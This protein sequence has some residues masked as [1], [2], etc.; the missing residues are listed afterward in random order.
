MSGN[1]TDNDE[2]PRLDAST[3][4]DELQRLWDTMLRLDPDWD[5]NGWLIE[6]ANE[7]MKIIEANL[8]RE[9]MRLEQRI[10]RLEALANRIGRDI[11]LDA[12]GTRQCNLFDVFGPNH[13]VEES[14]DIDD[15]AWEIHPAAVHLNYLPADIGD[16]PLLAVCAQAILLHIELKAADGQL[17][18]TLESLGVALIPRG[19]NSDELVEALEWLLEQGSVVETGENEFVLG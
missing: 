6:R 12:E 15:D 4:P 16:D 13:S 7:E 1:P 3:L 19:I 14:Q 9:K 2:R 10:A 18:I 11:E 17:P 5:M 8:G